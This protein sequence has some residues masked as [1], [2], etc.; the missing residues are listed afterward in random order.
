MEKDIKDE[1]NKLEQIDPYT[2]QYSDTKQ[3][4]DTKF[5]QWNSEYS[6]VTDISTKEFNKDNISLQSSKKKIHEKSKILPQFMPH[7]QVTENE[8]FEKLNPFDINYIKNINNNNN[9]H[10]KPIF[11]FK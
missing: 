5:I 7:Q 10:R 9:F 8:H 1:K 4:I 3:K 11:F 6:E 2:S